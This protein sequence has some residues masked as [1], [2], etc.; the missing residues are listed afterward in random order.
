M[1]AAKVHIHQDKEK[2]RLAQKQIVLVGL[3]RSSYWFF[4]IYLVIQ[5]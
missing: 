4:T 5:N 3:L 2:Q 1:S